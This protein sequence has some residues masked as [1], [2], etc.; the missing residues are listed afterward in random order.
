MDEFH[1]VRKEIVIEL[2]GV[3]EK[4]KGLGVERERKILSHL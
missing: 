4:M 3:F 2:L 1:L